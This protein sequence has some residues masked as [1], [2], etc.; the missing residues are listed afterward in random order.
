[1][2][3]NGL[4]FE[5]WLDRLIRSSATKARIATASQG[6]TPRKMVE[7]G[8]GHSHEATDP[9]AWQDLRN[10]Q[11][12]AGNIAE[13][14]AAADPEGAD[15]YRRNAAAF[16]ERLASLDAWVREQ[17]AT[18][19]EAR[20]I[21]VTSHDAFGYFGA[22]YGVRFEAPQGMS[23]ESEPSAAQVAALIRQVRA[24]HVTAVFIENMTNPALLERLARDAGAKVQGELF[25][26]SLS[27]PDGPAATY[28][29]M[30][31]HNV[32]LLVPAMRG[33]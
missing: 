9:H 7:E 8:H 27:P 3:R 30:F 13:A 22:A 10:G 4:G 1:M 2:V 5:P 16:R 15:L 19:P 28:E 18:V 33:A 24:K 20:R 29:A 6:V 26:D 23:T 11:A 31:R 21:V 25:S 17:V 12:Y 14:L 32:G